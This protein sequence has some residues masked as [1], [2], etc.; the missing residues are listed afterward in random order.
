VHPTGGSLRVFRHFAWL[1]VGSDK[2]ALSRPTHQRVTQAVGLPVLRMKLS[3]NNCNKPIRA[4][5]VQVK[6]KDKNFSMVCTKL[7][8]VFQDT[9]DVGFSAIGLSY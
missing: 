6:S 7:L 3:L 5:L 9:L 8:E 1:G 4:V 2:M